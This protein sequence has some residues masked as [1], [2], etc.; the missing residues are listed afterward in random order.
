MFNTKKQLNNLAREL[1]F[2]FSSDGKVRW[3]KWNDTPVFQ[4]H[5]KSIG[6]DKY[7]NCF[8]RATIPATGLFARLEALEKYL[9]IE[10]QENLSKYIKIKKTKKE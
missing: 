5:L 9:G 10:Y 7:K 8:T 2:Y 6:Y 3:T 1:G 4:K